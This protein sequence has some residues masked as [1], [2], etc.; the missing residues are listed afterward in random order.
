[1]SAILL[2]LCSV[3]GLWAQGGWDVAPCLELCQI[4][5]GQ[6]EP[7]NVLTS[8]R[9]YKLVNNYSSGPGFATLYAKNV[10]VNPNTSETVRLLKAGV[11]HTVMCGQS[12]GAPSSV[13][14][15][16]YSPANAQKFRAQMQDLGFKQTG[17][18]ENGYDVW[19]IEGLRILDG[20]DKQGK[21][22]MYFFFIKN[23]NQP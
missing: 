15:S 14:V 3:A 13:L 1:M 6:L 10:V 11:S 18:K 8:N 9:G 17:Q 4:V 12:A 23:E 16:F 20:K 19:G 2:S 7:A 22:N 21:Y 5:T